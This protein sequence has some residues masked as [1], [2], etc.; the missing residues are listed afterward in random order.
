MKRKMSQMAWVDMHV[1]EV[2]AEINSLLSSYDVR[3]EFRRHGWNFFEVVLL[4]RE[5][6]TGKWIPFCGV[7]MSEMSVVFAL[8]LIYGLLSVIVK[9]VPPEIGEDQR[10]A[11][12]ILKLF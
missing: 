10:Q 7:G 5:K 11:Q 2:L 12:D 8:E 1:K 6:N 4:V 3:I 9:G